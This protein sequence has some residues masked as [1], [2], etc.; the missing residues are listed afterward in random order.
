MSGLLVG[1]LEPF[2]L[3]SGAFLL[4]ELEKFLIGFSF[5]LSVD[6]CVDGVSATDGFEPAFVP[7]FG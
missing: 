3:C 7:D 5:F 2:G 4:F 1:A 6:G